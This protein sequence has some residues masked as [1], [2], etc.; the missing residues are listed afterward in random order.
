LTSLIAQIRIRTP[1]GKAKNIDILH[2]LFTVNGLKSSG[3]FTRQVLRRSIN[4]E[5]MP[6]VEIRVMHPLD[7]L[8]SRMHNAAGLVSDKGPH[9]IT[10]ARWAI[11]VAREAVLRSLASKQGGKDRVGAMVQFIYK[12]AHSQAGR[13]VLKDHGLEVLHSIPTDEIRNAEPVFDLQLAKIVAALEK[14]SIVITPE[15]VIPVD[16]PRG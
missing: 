4:V 6:G 2:L 7:L 3:Q 1:S 10:Q 5:L 8:E 12:L 13:R 9:V 11:Q 15:Q 14:R 16:R